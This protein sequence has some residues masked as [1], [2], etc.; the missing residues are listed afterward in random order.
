[1]SKN[2]RITENII[3]K[4]LKRVGISEL[5]GFLVEEQ[6]SENPL[7]IKLL[8]N[9]SKSGAGMGKPEF[10]ITKSKD[11]DFVIVIECKPDISHHESKDKNKFRD[12]AV[13]GALLYASY[14]SKE[15]NV[16]AVGASGQTENSL[17]I[18]TFYTL[19]EQQVLQNFVTKI[20]ILLII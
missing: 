4:K 1:M 15:F 2:E 13:D 12:F 14:L 9:S 16:I 17:K 5:N 10:I 20:S 19:K 7:I 11:K 3:R 6:K 8:K 18:S